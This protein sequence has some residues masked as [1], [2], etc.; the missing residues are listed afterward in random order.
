MLKVKRH[1]AVLIWWLW[2]LGYV[3]KTLC[4]MYSNAKFTMDFLLP[5]E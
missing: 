2:S 5:E 1:L 3:E 4:V